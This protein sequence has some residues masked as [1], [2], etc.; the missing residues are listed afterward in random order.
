MAQTGGWEEAFIAI[1]D[2]PCP[3]CIKH[4][5]SAQI[6]FV[7]ID[8]KGFE[9]DFFKRRVEDFN[10]LSKKIAELYGITF[11]KVYRREKRI[12]PLFE[13]LAS[14]E[15]KNTFVKEVTSEELKK[16]FA[17]K[18][19]GSVYLEAKTKDGNLLRLISEPFYYTESEKEEFLPS[20]KGLSGRFH[21][22]SF[23]ILSVVIEAKRLGLNL[24]E[25]KSFFA[26]KEKISASELIWA[27]KFNLQGFIEKSGKEP[28]VLSKE[29]MLK[30]LVQMISST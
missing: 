28:S 21:L 9:K 30:L 23:P 12:E 20:D 5:A 1:T 10:L 15:K 24:E 18:E 14:T 25:K 27:L 17:T 16:S 4:I 22:K 26:I 11:F 6:K 3:N 7:Y 13:T 29:Y 8:H 2:P 19:S